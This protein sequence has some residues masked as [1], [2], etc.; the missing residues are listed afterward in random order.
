MPRKKKVDWKD[1]LS[2][3][4]EAKIVVEKEKKD[5]IALSKHREKKKIQ[6]V[7]ERGGYVL[8]R[9]GAGDDDLDTFSLDSD[10][11]EIDERGLIDNNFNFSNSMEE[12]NKN[13]KVKA[14]VEGD[15]KILGDITYAQVLESVWKSGGLITRVARR[16]NISVHYVH[17]I[18]DKYKSLNQI[19]TE[20]RESVLDEVE[21]HLLD[22]IRSGDKGDTIAMIFYLKCHGK[23]RGYIDRADIKKKSSVRMKIVPIKDAKP[24]VAAKS[25]KVLEFKKAWGSDVWESGINKDAKEK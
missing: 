1:I 17:K 6:K 14:E 8:P 3:E 2:S 7:K 5:E 11:D 4:T 12:F 18:F 10:I 15:K 25:E 24:T 21:M 20:F 23:E 9:M 13:V 22:K 16:L 19:F